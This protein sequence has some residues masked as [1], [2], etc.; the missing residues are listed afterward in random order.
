MNLPDDTQ[1]AMDKDN[2]LLLGLTACAL[3]LSFFILWGPKLSRRSSN[4]CSLIGLQNL[5]LTCFLNS[6]LQAL[7]SCPS[8][9]DWLQSCHR[10]GSVTDSLLSILKLLCYEREPDTSDEVYSPEDLICNLRGK[11][12]PIFPQEQ[13]PH[14]LFLHLLTALEEEEQKATPERMESLLDA[15]DSRTDLISEGMR[16]QSENST[17]VT[18]HG[19]VQVSNKIVTPER[20]T[21]IPNPFRG[22]LASQLSC[23][24][25]GSKS[26]VVYDKFDSLSLALPPKGTSFKLQNLLE[27]FVSPEQVDGF[28]CDFCNKDRPPDDPPLLSQANKAIKIGKLPKCLCF[29]ISRTYIDSNGYMYKRE[30]YVDFPEYLHMKN[31]THTNSMLKERKAKKIGVSLASGVSGGSGGGGNSTCLKFPK[32]AAEGSV[33]GGIESDPTLTKYKSLRPIALSESLPPLSVS[34]NNNIT[35]SS[36]LIINNTNSRPTSESLS[37]HGPIYR[38]KSVVE[39]RGTVDSG[40]F[41]TY[42]RGPL[43]SNI[44][45]RSNQF[46]SQSESRWFFT[47]DDIVR[48]SSLCDALSA[49]AYLLF[50]EKC[51]STSL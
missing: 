26:A 44:R 4:N 33:I 14:E 51:V 47:S 12:W 3:G 19:D 20:P 36:P 35:Q 2:I 8:F 31:Y 21:L 24:K 18:S 49:Y 22:Y 1:K 48:K 42:R 10:N 29:H 43:E 40:H 45:H 6:L 17:S 41:V 38:L 11:V 16:S 25:C 28:A 46:S 13:D 5:G 34:D 50:Y 27:D 7:A 23:L 30:H 15:L 39:H 9:I 37:S 32:G